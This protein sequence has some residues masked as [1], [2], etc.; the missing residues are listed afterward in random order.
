MITKK[1]IAEQLHDNNFPYSSDMKQWVDKKFL[2]GYK[3]FPSLRELIEACGKETL[4]L[5]FYNKK[6]YCGLRHILNSKGSFLTDT[7]TL[8]IDYEDYQ[9]GNTPEESIAKLWLEL[10]KNT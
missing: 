9:T 5:W 3:V 10:N 6:Y 1:C 8:V 7:H 4:T 2:E